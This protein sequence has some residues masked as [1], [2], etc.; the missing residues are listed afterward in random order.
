MLLTL[1][2]V[3]VVLFHKCYR[4]NKHEMKLHGKAVLLYSIC[5]IF[6]KLSHIYEY[7]YLIQAYDDGKLSHETAHWKLPH[8]VICF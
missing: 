1:L 4:L 7:F 3:L 2:L 5:L 6:Q 8:S